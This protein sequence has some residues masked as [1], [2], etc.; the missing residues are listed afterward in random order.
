VATSITAFIDFFR[1]GPM[2]Q[3]IGIFGMADFQRVFAAPDSGTRAAK[4]GVIRKADAGGA[5]TGC[6]RSIPTARC[7]EQ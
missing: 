1:E 5:A 3:A 6:S 2:D 7:V 4:A